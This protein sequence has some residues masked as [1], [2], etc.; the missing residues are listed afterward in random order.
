MAYISAISSQIAEPGSIVAQR[1]HSVG[2]NP[3]ALWMVVLHL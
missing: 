1:A 3:D 2:S